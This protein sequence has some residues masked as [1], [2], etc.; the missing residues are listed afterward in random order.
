MTTRTGDRALW[1][2]LGSNDLALDPSADG[3]GYHWVPAT[4][5]G[6]LP[7]G[8]EMIAT[9]YQT[10]SPFGTPPI[11]GADGGEIELEFPAIGQPV[12]ALAG[13][14]PSAID[15][16]GTILQHVFGTRTAFD[17][18]DI[19]GAVGEVNPSAAQDLIPMLN[20]LPRPLSWALGL[21]G[22]RADSFGDTPADGVSPGHTRY[23]YAEGGGPHLAAVYRRGADFYTLL[24]CR[25]SS[26]VLSAE[27]GQPWSCKAT[28]RFDSRTRDVAKTAL[29]VADGVLGGP[30]LRGILSPVT[31]NGVRYPVGSAEIDLG[32]EAVRDMSLEGPQG[33]VADLGLGMKPVITLT[34][35]SSDAFDE[36]VRD[37]VIGPLTIQLGGGNYPGAAGEPIGGMCAHFERASMTEA[38]DTD[39]NGLLRKSVKFACVF[40]GAFR[41]TADAAEPIQVVRC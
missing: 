37:V 3:S 16:F 2:A 40:P 36:M 9:D 18:V 35:H 5:L 8:R 41:G 22:N 28:L 31:F 34:P 13:Q 38:E 29:P 6:E 10:G 4:T 24:G 7:T 12:G 21:G 11:P 26:L 33:R 20:N 14:S 27:A 15:W 32:I 23:R 1:V 39:D 17:G 30:P 25:I 19:T